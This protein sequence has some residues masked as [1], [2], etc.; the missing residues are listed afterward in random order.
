MNRTE[1]RR[2]RISDVAALARVDRAVVSKVIN[3]SETLNIRPETRE[4]VWEAIR[5]L[6]YRPNA[7]ARSLRTAKTG[8]F[9]L[10]IPDFA[11]PIYAS[12]I[13][14][15]QRAA[16]HYDQLVLTASAADPSDIDHYMNALSAGRLDG[17]LLAGGPASQAV[18]HQIDALGLPSVLLNR[19]GPSSARY[20]VLDDERAAS[21]AV[22]HL[23]A[24]GH[25]R[26][27]HI[28]G[29]QSA[30]TGVRRRRGFRDAMKSAGLT[31]G[32]G[33]VIEADYTSEGGFTAMRALLTR[34]PVPSAVVVANVASAIGALRAA[35]DAGFDVPTDLS[36]V[37]IHD[38]PLA[39]YLEPPLTTVHMPVEELGYRGLELLSTVAA[40][41][42]IEEELDHPMHLVIRKSTAPL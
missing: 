6:D 19:R 42:R 22:E 18:Q 33:H 21:I 39:D 36:I 30:D 10:L 29:P 28:A 40:D 26:I 31:V 12:I 14:G 15:A 23:T 32:R 3:G 17:V 2:V 16:T 1:G 9:G 4:R 41:R 25:R 37:S 20:V 11:N 5:T 27:G 24:L 8:M 38:L 35:R 34:R 7:V 13:T